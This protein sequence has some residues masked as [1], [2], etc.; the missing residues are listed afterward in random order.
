MF[1]L[2][3][4]A[5]SLPARVDALIESEREI[6]RVQAR[7]VRVIAAIADDPYSDVVAPLLEREFFKEEIRAALGES[8]ESVNGRL[9][10]ARSLVHRL[11]ATLAA[12]ESGSI[13]LRHARH[14]VDAVRLLDDT[15]A[16]AVED[17]VLVFGWVGIS[18]RSAAR[19]AAKSSRPIRGR[20]KRRSRRRWPSAGCGRVRSSTA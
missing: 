12:V 3:P 9:L 19:C 17:A 20:W 14:L 15:D 1:D 11:S 2:D 4:A 7:Q 18:G 16:L 5:L 10:L 6:A 13:T 8:A